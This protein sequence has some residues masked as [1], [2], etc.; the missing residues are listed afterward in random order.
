MVSSFRS[1]RTGYDADG[2]H[3]A[4]NP[5]EESAMM[6]IHFQEPR[7]LL[8]LLTVP[9]A[10]LAALYAQ[11]KRTEVL[12][13]ISTDRMLDGPLFTAARRH[14]R[15]SLSATL[16]A[17]SLVCIA[18]AR[19]G[20]NPRK[21]PLTQNGRDVIF[22]LDVSRS[23]QAADRVPDRLENIK[24]AIIDCLDEFENER[25]ALVV[26][27]G[28]ATITCPLTRDYGFFLST[29]DQANPYSVSHGGTRI[30]DALRKTAD[31]LLTE[32]M[33]G[34][35]DVI[36]LTDGGDHDSEAIEAVEQLNQLN[37]SLIVIGVG[38]DSH[39]AEIPVF[40]EETGEIGVLMHENKP[41]LTSQ[42][43]AFLKTLAMS[44][45]DGLFLNAG[46]RALDLH[47]VYARFAEHLATREYFGEEVERHEEGFQVFIGC[48][49]AVLLLIG[50]S[51][52]LRLIS[53]SVT[54]IMLLLSS[55]Y[56]HAQTPS[57]H[58]SL[59]QIQEG[60]YDAAINRIRKTAESHSLNAGFWYNAGYA[61]Y[62]LGH[63]GEA[64]NAFNES[65]S[66]ASDQTLQLNIL[67]NLGTTCYQYSRDVG[68]TNRSMA[69]SLV[70]QGTA[71]LEAALAVAPTNQ[72]SRINLEL[73]RR[74]LRSFQQADEAEEAYQDALEDLAR[75]VREL[76]DQQAKAMD[77]GGKLHTMKADTSFANSLA[78]R[79][80][81]IESGI[82]K[83]HAAASAIHIP[84]TLVFE[85]GEA[86]QQ[87]AAGHLETAAQHANQSI[88]PI[89][90]SEQEQAVAFQE[91][92]L[93]ELTKALG[94]LPSDPEGTPRDPS[95]NGE[96]DEGDDGDP[97][98]GDG[99][100]G[101]YSEGDF[102]YSGDELP[103]D[104]SPS[105]MRLDTQNQLLPPPNITPQELLDREAAIN[106]LR[107]EKRSGRA[108]KVEMDW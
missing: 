92:T 25:V 61:H 56:A 100:E 51:G 70:T 20:W 95:D 29:L 24:T 28:S 107:A 36:L 98:D 37:T 99:E 42:D 63:Y 73:S 33:Q 71:Y 15:R 72:S 52:E 13:L 34:F 22:V 3:L 45:T 31:K 54:L 39:P 35:Q 32:D 84:D 40:N 12:T 101:E 80:Q 43:T 2:I 65:M 103:P 83:A 38:S 68:N 105:A 7:M 86:P 46:T 91:I 81:K 50:L 14:R 85:P 60:H 41:V 96:S 27:S 94:A 89:R 57:F 5:A 21:E 88:D 108:G 102:Q 106:E 59:K 87:I 82:R 93:S 47:N 90:Q 69:I 19:P 1:G 44:A 26:F 18:L 66:M 97:E 11:R 67:H 55:S 78:A 6:G 62:R 17:M 9:L 64:L 74:L 53:K 77:D 10:A 4:I 23:M 30:G 79:Q 76:I 58:E 49:L 48:A 8:L 16:L 75:A 104:M